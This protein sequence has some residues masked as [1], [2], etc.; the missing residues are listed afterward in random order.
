[1]EK[2]EAYLQG[3]FDDLLRDLDNELKNLTTKSDYHS[4]GFRCTVRVYD[5]YSL[6]NRGLISLTILLI[7]GESE[8]FVSLIPSGGAID[9][10]NRAHNKL[11]NRAIKIIEAYS[12]EV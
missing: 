2:Y 7:E 3:N 1:M 10:V 9:G 5:K 12:P 8:L 4:G 11:V 6:W